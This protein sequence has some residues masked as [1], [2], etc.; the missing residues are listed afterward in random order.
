MRTLPARSDLT[1]QTHE[2]LRAAI[3]SGELSPCAPL[4]QEELAERLGVSRQPISHALKLLKQEGL[5]VDRGRK[6]QM[7]A[8]IDAERLL[9]L[10][11]VRG[12]LDRLAAQLVASAAPLLSTTTDQLEQL[13][14]QCRIADSNGDIAS[15][16]EA[17]IAF[18][19]LLHTLSG[20]G[21]IAT[22]TE[23]LWPH[24]ERAMHTVLVHHP[25]RSDIWREHRAIADAIIAGDALKAGELAAQHAEVAGA[26]THQRLLEI[27]TD[28]T[29]QS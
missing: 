28:T 13:I 9:A 23:T 18:H 8:P 24:I 11:Q 20:N 1:V 16:V 12:A 6:G 21:E 19:R 14:E 3:I 26:N 17:D 27:Q 25:V 29:K 15:M 4:A 10:Y 2:V 7:V 5:V 22:A